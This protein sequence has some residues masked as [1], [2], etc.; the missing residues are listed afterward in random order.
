MYLIRRKYNYFVTKIDLK[1]FIIQPMPRNL[2]FIGLLF[3]LTIGTAQ[4]N[5]KGQIAEPQPG[6]TIYLSIIEDY[7]RFDKISMEQILKKTTTDSLGYF[8]FSGDNLLD[9]NR[10]YRIHIDDCSESNA[11]TAHFFGSCEFSK[12]I[13]FIAKNTDTITFPTSFDNE[14]LCEITSTN[15]TSSVFLDIDVLKE[16][17]AYDFNE[18]RSS[19][20]NRLNSK[21]WFSTL[22]DYSKK[23]N[24]PLA[25]LYIFSFLSDKR[26][27]TYS[28]YLKDILNSNY[29]NDLAERLSATYADAP[30]TELYLNELNID[31]QIAQQNTAQFNLW[32]WLLPLLLVFSVGLN[33]YYII[34]HRSNA[35]KAQNDFFSKLTEQ[36][37]NIVKQILDN[38][39]NKEVAA[40]MFIS[41]ST[42]KTHINNIY[43]KLEVASRE[44]IKQRYQ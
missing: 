23:T 24:E 1:T 26:N 3:S 40:A 6:K 39:S 8:N 21:K 29:Y 9:Q 37:N 31:Q 38:K 42:V 19:A 2:I 12:R 10:V 36:E 44:E 5:F 22:Q 11:N 16:Q 17:M 41:V 14:A 30:F 4:Y 7:R 25:E 18:F 33:V 20:N 34:R 32:K 27:E 35:K 28:Y 13:L 43:K 15:T